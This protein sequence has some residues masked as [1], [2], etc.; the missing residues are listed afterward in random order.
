MKLSLV[1]A[2]R[3][4][5]SHFFCNVWANPF[6]PAMGASISNG[7]CRWPSLNGS[8]LL[9]FSR[10]SF[11]TGCGRGERTLKGW[12]WWSP[13]FFSGA[14]NVCTSA[15][16]MDSVYASLRHK[17]QSTTEQ[18]KS[19]SNKKARE[20]KIL[21]QLSMNLLPNNIALYITILYVIVIIVMSHMTQIILCH[22]FP[23]RPLCSSCS[24]QPATLAAQ[25]ASTCRPVQQMDHPRSK[26][27]AKF[28]CRS[29]CYMCWF[30]IAP[31]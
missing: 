28:P 22:G 14:C 24:S 2:C 31:Y 21:C 13:L 10:P 8:V 17:S 1:D 4:A 6:G 26:D 30:T 5:V 27:M 23:V 9:Q 20:N 25:A 3:A 11:S 18:E 15:W 12:E 29:M 16:Y 7:T 19:F